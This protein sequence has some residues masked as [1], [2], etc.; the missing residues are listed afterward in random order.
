MKEMYIIQFVD[1]L[2]HFTVERDCQHEKGSMFKRL[3]SI[4]VVGGEDKVLPHFASD[5]GKNEFQ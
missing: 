1:A 2:E 5:T 3:S 4:L